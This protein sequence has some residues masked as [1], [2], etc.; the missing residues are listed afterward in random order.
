VDEEFTIGEV[1]LRGLKLCEP[2]GHLERL[3]AKP[4]REPLIHRG[5]LRAQILKSGTIRVGDRV[6]PARD[7]E[8]RAA[9][10]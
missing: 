6:T 3:T 2:C 1:R 8:S 9:S 7:I 4:V 10:A 5:G